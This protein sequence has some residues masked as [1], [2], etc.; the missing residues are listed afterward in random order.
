VLDRV[1]SPRK[2]LVVAPR[3]SH[4]GLVLSTQ[5]RTTAWPEIVAWLRDTL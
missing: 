3:L 5:A 4:R 2:S 1:G